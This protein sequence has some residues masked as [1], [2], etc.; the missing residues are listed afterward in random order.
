MRIIAITN[1]K[2]GCGKTTT[3]VNIAVG[4]AEKGSKILVVDF[5][6]QGHSTIGLGYDIDN[7]PITIYDAITKPQV[8]ISEVISS[9][10]FERLDLAPSN[11]LLSGA[12]IELVSIAFGIGVLKSG[13]RRL[14]RL[15][16]SRRHICP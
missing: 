10:K 5:D 9:T 12:E 16:S 13:R 3:A 1:Q 8:S 6:P 7:L 15:R 4:L 11:V 14:A 2:G